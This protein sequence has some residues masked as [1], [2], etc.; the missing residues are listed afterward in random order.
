MQEA[1]DSVLSK[2]DAEPADVPGLDVMLSDGSV[3]TGKEFCEAYARN[4]FEWV[5]LLSSEFTESGKEITDR[6]DLLKYS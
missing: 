6:M 1:L 5:C 2:Y 4:E 3:I